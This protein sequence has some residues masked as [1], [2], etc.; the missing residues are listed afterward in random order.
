MRCFHYYDYYIVKLI[1]IKFDY[2]I[3]PILCFIFLST[4]SFLIT[5]ILFSA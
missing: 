5:V 4:Q 2:G 3:L 1:K